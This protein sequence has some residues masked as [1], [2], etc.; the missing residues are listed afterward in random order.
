MSSPLAPLDLVHDAIAVGMF[1]Q[2]QWDERADERARR[3]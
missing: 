2:I 1:G 3:D